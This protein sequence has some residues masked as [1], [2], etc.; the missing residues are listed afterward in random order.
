MIKAVTM[1]PKIGQE[2]VG[3]ITQIVRDR[4]GKEIGIIVKFAPNLEGMV[5]I[6]QLLGKKISKISHS[7]KIGEKIPVELKYGS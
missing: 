5:H 6:S 2:F 3:T 4:F 1:E 7:F